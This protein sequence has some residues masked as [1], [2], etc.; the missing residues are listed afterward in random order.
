M[1]SKKNLN[2]VKSIVAGL[3]QTYREGKVTTPMYGSAILDDKEMML[4]G[5][6]KDIDPNQ[7]YLIERTIMVPVNHYNELLK[8]IQRRGMIAIDGYCKTVNAIHKNISDPN[9]PIDTHSQ[10]I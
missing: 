8:L 4:T 10:W 5:G 1:L 2:K 9:K 3:P 7:K 6:G